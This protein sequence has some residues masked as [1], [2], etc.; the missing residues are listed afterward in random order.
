MLETAACAD[1]AGES[2]VGRGEMRRWRAL[3]ASAEVEDA[4]DSERL[5]AVERMEEVGLRSFKRA[6]RAAMATV[7]CYVA[8]SIEAG[9]VLV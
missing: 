3:Y 7:C 5:V 8:V 2:E 4:V 6:L 9:V 1:Q